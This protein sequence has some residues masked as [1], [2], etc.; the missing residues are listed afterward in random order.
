MSRIFL[1][2]FALFALGEGVHLTVGYLRALKGLPA[3]RVSRFLHW[4][5][6]VT[7]FVLF[8]VWNRFR[9]LP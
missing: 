2:L 4:F 5:F 8:F 6:A 9:T 1:L 3:F 7:L